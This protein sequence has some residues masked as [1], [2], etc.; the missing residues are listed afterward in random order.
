MYVQ[1][2]IPVEAI[3][4]DVPTC[5]WLTQWITK[6]T[7]LTTVLVQHIIISILMIRHAQVNLINTAFGVLEICYFNLALIARFNLP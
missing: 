7:E 5:V 1:V 6:T 4:E 3:M 2:T